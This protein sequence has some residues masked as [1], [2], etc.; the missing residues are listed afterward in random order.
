M[1]IKLSPTLSGYQLLEPMDRVDL[2][3]LQ[4]WAAHEAFKVLTASGY[5]FQVISP[6]AHTAHVTPLP[7]A[8]LSAVQQPEAPPAWR[9]GWPPTCRASTP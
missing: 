7:E 2:V 9:A 3:A 6:T 5:L 4:I 8:Q 1:C